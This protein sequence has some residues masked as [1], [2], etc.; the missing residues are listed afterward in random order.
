MIINYLPSGG[1]ASL[2]PIPDESSFT[3]TTFTDNG[4]TYAQ[5]DSFN[6]EGFTGES[7]TLPSTVGDN[8]PVKAIN[9]E[10]FKT[11]QM[12]NVKKVVVP[13]TD[14]GWK[15]DQFGGDTFAKSPIQEIDFAFFT[16]NV[17]RGFTNKVI[18]LAYNDNVF[19]KLVVGNKNSISLIVENDFRNTLITEN[20]FPFASVI[21][22]YAFADCSALKSFENS[23]V[24][25]GQYA[26]QNTISLTGS[27]KFDSAVS[28]ESYAFANS[29]ASEISLKS[30]TSCA[31]RSIF[32]DSKNLRFVH[33]NSLTGISFGGSTVAYSWFQG[34]DALEKIYVSADNYDV[35]HDY[36]LNLPYTQYGSDLSTLV[37]IE[38]EV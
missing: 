29:S 33:L 27:L 38:E 28:V 18:K 9:V 22:D 1:K 31:N 21:K 32:K 4:V 30:L 26:F 36:L 24:S 15:A 7:V 16:R 5:L 19:S 6:F 35:V 8:I 37:E 34:C 12:G 17:I 11:A 25:I 13:Y 14:W 2:P 23:A 3:Y 20:P 10:C